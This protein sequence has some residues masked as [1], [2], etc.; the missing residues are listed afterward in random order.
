M[1]IGIHASNSRAT[2][3]SFQSMVTFL[4]AL[5]SY[6]SEHEIVAVY[7]NDQENLKER[8]KGASW[9]WVDLK[10]ALGITQELP[11]NRELAPRIRPIVQALNL[12]I[13]IFP[14]WTDG[15]WEWG[16]PYGFTV[17]DLQHRLQPEFSEV[18][19]GKELGGSWKWREEF[20]KKGLSGA[21][22]I[23]VDSEEGKRNVLEFYDVQAKRIFP[24]PPSVP[25][26]CF[27][28]LTE[29]ERVGL[30][31]AKNLP[32]RFL[33]YPAQFWPHKNHY[34]VVEALGILHKEK[35]LEIP[36]VLVGRTFPEWSVYDAIMA[37]AGSFGIA[38][39][40]FHFGYV[41]DKEL[42]AFYQSAQGLLMPTYF[43]PANIPYIEAMYFQCPII[44]SDL[45]GIREQI[46][47]AG[48]LVN[49]RSSHSIADAVEKLWVDEELRSKLIKEGTKQLTHFLPEAV[50]KEIKK[51][52]DVLPTLVGEND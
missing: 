6:A 44:G 23:F 31:Q 4:D 9:S 15:C 10:S 43:G 19:Y 34:R 42:V 5:H 3:G 16:V 11:S 2:G 28:Q 25:S 20:F 32:Q 50:E 13:L 26:T 22:V 37:L 30:I 36:L 51:C 41:E 38:K 48:L 1:R 47:S 40:I 21:S 46:G 17:F 12:D 8:Y 7:L 14:T 18:S 45:P 24:I 35:G 27:L 52:I 39:N 49:P 29:E 33:F